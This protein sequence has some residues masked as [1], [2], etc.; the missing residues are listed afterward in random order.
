M[1][2]HSTASGI[3][4]GIDPT[5][6][7]LQSYIVSE[8]HRRRIV[9]LIFVVYWLLILEGALRKWVLPQYQKELFFI[10][11]PFVIAI[12]F[13]CIVYRVWPRQQL[14]TIVALTWMWLGGLL[15]LLE[16]MS[17]VIDSRMGLLL[18]I[19]GWRGYFLYIPL[20]FVIGECFRR[21]DL[22]RLV[23]FTLLFSIPIA[24]LSVLQASAPPESVL[25]AGFGDNPADT[26]V[27]LDVALG[28]MRTSGTFTSSEGQ[29]L[30]I[31][32]L[33][34]M[35][36]WVWSLPSRQRPLRG[37]ALAA[38]S[39]AVF[40]N[41]AVSGQR[42]AFVLAL[43][44][45]GVAVVGAALLTTHRSSWR[46][47]RIVVGLAIVAGV[48]MPVL[49][50][51]QLEALSVRAAGAAAGDSRYSY[52]IVNRALGDFTHFTDILSDA[53]WLGYG[54]GMGANGTSRMSL[55]VPVSA[56]DDWSRNIVD[57][58]PIL[59]FFF[60]AFRIALVVW[61]LAGAL[62]AAKRSNDLGPALLLG[63]FG[64]FLLYGQITGQGSV[65]G[66]AWLFAGFCVAARLTAHNEPVP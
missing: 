57:L 50:S 48:A 24:A 9:S 54:L 34:S 56:E 18:A 7:W 14:L 40:T 55:F 13:L 36:V 21:E 25:N 53:P 12:Y 33:I 59:G 35:I 44:V 1:R 65:N 51:R 8:R 23:R 30:F 58:G 6:G 41:L 37:T 4:I 49:F 63:F 32:S 61:L 46:T 20:A 2:S 39:L 19:Y 38:A 11:D 27:V 28:F 43:M 22:L 5:S 26:F 42:S 62:A 15:L 3:N 60:I 45:L 17:G 52:G 16:I 47:L 29:T 31:G 66:Y 10:R 64:I